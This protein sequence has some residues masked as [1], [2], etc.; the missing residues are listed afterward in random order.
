MAELVMDKKGFEK[1]Y[2]NNALVYKEIKEKFGVSCD[3]KVRCYTSTDE[4]KLY[5]DL[6]VDIFSSD[7]YRDSITVAT[8]EDYSPEDC[9]SF[10][11]KVE[12]HRKEL[13][14]LKKKLY[15]YLKNK[16]DKVELAE[17][18]IQ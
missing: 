13:S 5:T 18:Y 11:E 16:I 10:W 7:E 2:R 3:F 15:I 9:D 17:D 12:S 4:D 14:G 6:E 1:N 8:I